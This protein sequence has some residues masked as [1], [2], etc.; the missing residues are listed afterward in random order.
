MERPMATLGFSF[1]LSLI[2]ASFLELKMNAVFTAVFFVAFITFLFIKSFRQNRRAMTVLLAATAAFSMYSIQEYMTFRPMQKWDGKKAMLR[3]ETV[4][5]VDLNRVT[6]RVLDGDIAKG[7]RISMYLSCTE[8]Y[9]APYDILEGEF[10]LFTPRDSRDGQIRGFSKSQKIY[11]NAFPA[12]Y[13]EININMTSPKTRPFMYNILNARKTARNVVMSQPGMTDVA[14]LA[15]GIAFGFRQDI[16]SN[17]KNDFRISGVSHLLAVS[18][19]HVTV[20][21]Q[22]ILALLLFLKIPRRAAL[23]AAGA[24]VLFFMAL[25]GFTPSVMRAGIMCLVFITA[26]MIGREPDSLN[27]LGIAVFAITALNPYAVNDAGLLLSFSATYGLL[28]IYPKIRR[29]TSDRLKNGGVWARI[30]ARPVSALYITVAATIPTLPVILF[31]FGQI[32]I[33]SPIANL[34]MVFPASVV[35]ITT[36][37]AVP[38]YVF[39]PLR[40]ISGA[41][42][43]VVEL[44]ARYLAGVAEFLACLPMASVWV[45][46]SFM[47]LG[48]P[49]AIGLVALGWYLLGRRGMR[50]AALWSVIA[51]LCG[52]LTYGILMKGVTRITVLSTNDAVMLLERDGHT[53]VVITGNDDAVIAAVNELRKRNVRTVDFLIIPFADD[54]CAF[55]SMFFTD[56]IGVNCL[57]TGR[58]GEYTLTVESLPAAGRISLEDGDIGFWKDCIAELKDNWLR[59]TVDKTRILFGGYSMNASELDSDFRQ[60]NLLVLSGPPRHISALTAQAG[61]LCSMPDT[62]SDKIKAIPRD[63]Y[64]IYNTSDNNLT[65]LTRG[66]GDITYKG[67]SIGVD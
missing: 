23:S 34:L 3:V 28:A 8:L 62:L 2:I 40:F 30:I 16:S 59:L 67:G 18:G 66:G 31:T 7:T 15:S 35:M 48:I 20:L 27:S 14:G 54:E 19:L 50:V 9:P 46:Q 45:G 36:C 57:I 1:F 55:Y 13:G 17:M 32:S 42:F 29:V 12:E 43:W 6:V 26:Q 52:V 49:A 44:F 65:F 64:P 47:Y 33:I 38:L 37:I 58:S 4:D 21:S 22:V 24:G 10:K 51:L 41:V 53:G 25:T 5:W 11:L 61:V 60:T 63:S 39:E 56:N